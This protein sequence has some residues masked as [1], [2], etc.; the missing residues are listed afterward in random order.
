MKC[1]LSGELTIGAASRIKDDLLRALAGDGAFQLDTCGVTEVDAAGLQ[2][3]LGA[4]KSAARAN[5]PVLF[6]SES[7][8]AAVATGFALLGL[9]QLNGTLEVSL[10]GKEHIGR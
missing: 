10:H 6:P 1:T 9:D 2:L 8:G 5:I 7:R 4:F 3:L